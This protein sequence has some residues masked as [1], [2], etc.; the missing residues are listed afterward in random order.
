MGMGMSTHALEVVCWAGQGNAMAGAAREG[1]QH[2][3]VRGARH[4]GDEGGLHRVRAPTASGQGR[5]RGHNERVVPFSRVRAAGGRR[6]K[7]QGTHLSAAQ[8]GRCRS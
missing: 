4:A 5:A 1:S 6:E 8:T 7:A 2:W 3:G